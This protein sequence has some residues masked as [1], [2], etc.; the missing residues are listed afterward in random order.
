MDLDQS[1][2]PALPADRLRAE[3]A[4]A[5]FTVTWLRKP[6]AKPLADATHELT[7]LDIVVLELRD[8][9]GRIGFSYALSFD[10]GTQLL[11]R[12]IFDAAQETVGHQPVERRRIWREAWLRNEYLGREGLAAWGA[13]AVDIALYDLMARQAELPLASLL[14]TVRDSIPA[15]GSGGWTSYSIDELIAEAADY[16]GRG[17]K[18]VK[19]KVGGDRTIRQDADRVRAVRDAIGD[20][21]G[22]MIDANQGLSRTAAAQLARAVEPYDIGWFEEPIDAHDVDGYVELRRQCPLPLAMGER[23]FYAR[24]LVDI[25]TRGGVDVVMPDALRIG[26]VDEWLGTARLAELH[27]ARI[28]P[29]FYREFDVPLACSIPNAIVV[30]HFDWLDDLLDWDITFSD[31]A[32]HLTGAPGLGLR[33]R[34]EARR[35]WAVETRDARSG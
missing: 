7:C 35:D 16:V 32:Y 9:D 21:V 3:G 2:Q 14:G 11:A 20:D 27:G 34:E 24:G 30:E 5:D 31:G 25:I 8:T 28:A 29:H 18:A 13:A 17:F 4:I 1:T 10:Y 6:L 15:Y 19:V 23:N 22:L 12:T 26:G 33:L